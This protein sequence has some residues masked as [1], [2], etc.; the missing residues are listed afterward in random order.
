MKDHSGRTNEMGVFKEKKR[1]KNKYNCI[2]ATEI[3]KMLAWN[4]WAINV[5]DRMI[6]RTYRTL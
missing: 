4:N 2:I 5:I 1:N 3:N 6:T